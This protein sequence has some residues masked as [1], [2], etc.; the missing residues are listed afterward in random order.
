MM[1]VVGL[2]AL[3]VLLWGDLSVANVVSGVVVAVA[4]ITVFPSAG[5]HRRTIVRPLPAL[6]LTAVLVRELI[7]SNA[8]LTRDVLRR[9]PRLDPDLV[10]CH[11]ACGA[12]WVIALVANVLALSPG[13]VPVEVD[14]D[15]RLL[16]L[17]V[18]RVEEPDDMRRRVAH[19]EELV[20]RAFGSDEEIME[21]RR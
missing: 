19:L 13:T 12:P 14:A 3:W 18:L 4:V 20:L 8:L 1:R 2:V 10:E 7:V 16:R 17:H 11:M 21:L 5:V 9:R 6:R 15:K